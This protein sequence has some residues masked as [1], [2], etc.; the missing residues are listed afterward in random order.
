M[1]APSAFFGHQASEWPMLRR[2]SWLVAALRAVQR[3]HSPLD[4]KTLGPLFSNPPSPSLRPATQSLLM[5]IWS[6]T[7]PFIYLPSL[8]SVC[9]LG[10]SQACT[11]P[12]PHSAIKGRSIGSDS[13]ITCCSLLLHYHPSAL[14]SRLSY[15]FCFWYLLPLYTC[16]HFYLQRVSGTSSF[17]SSHSLEA[18]HHCLT[19]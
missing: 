5:Q 19:P 18:L 9:T 13:C 8:H 7:F 14:T 17:K 6:L 10:Y 11:A 3:R 4:P 2:P 12:T 16:I 1:K 15:S